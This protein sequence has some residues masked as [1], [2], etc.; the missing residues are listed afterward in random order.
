MKPFIVIQGPVATRSGYGNHTR[1]L[2]SALIKSNKYD[3]QI[4]SLP[5]GSCPTDALKSDNPEHVIINQCIARSNIDKKP[6]VFIQ[7]SVPNEFKPLGKYN[8][9][10]TAGIETTQVSHEFIE[11]CNRMDMNIVTSEHSKKG[12]IE[13][14]YDKVDDKTKQKVAELRLEKPID[15][16]FE[17]LDLNV[18]KK[19]KPSDIKQTVIDELSDIK[20]DFCFLFTGHWLKGSLGQDRKDVGMMIKTFCE[21]FKNKQGNNQPGL[22]LKTSHATFS[23]ID[24]DE[25]TKKIQQITAPYGNKAPNIYLLHGDLTDSEMNSL[26]N[27]PKIK[28]MLSFTKG[29][30][31]GRPL[32][33][34]GITGKPII[35]SNWSGHVDFLKYATLLPGELTPVH[36]SAAD[37]FILEQSKWF[38]VEYAYASKILQDCVS[39]YKKYY[40]TS[41]KQSHYVKTNF[42]LAQMAT[43]F[44]EIVDAGIKSVPQHVSLNLPKLKKVGNDVPKLKLPKLQK[45]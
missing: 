18:Y 4:I 7:I 21:S 28:A 15:V 1:D 11:G 8:I 10:I 16:L 26:Y 20:D 14:V 5:W 38:T 9:G 43:K 13:T 40:E 36:R 34:F 12:F 3:I 27:H 22:I 17:G 6:D 23:I 32:L 42:S 33:E 39:N 19:V 35:A 41:R 44:C 25:I 31:F 29:E 2:A 24:R 37:T 45:V 30:G